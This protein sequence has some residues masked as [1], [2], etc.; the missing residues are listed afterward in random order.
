LHVWTTL[1]KGTLLGL[2]KGTVTLSPNVTM[3]QFRNYYL[4]KYAPAFTKI[5]NV[6]L[7]EVT[8]V[9]GEAIGSNF[10]E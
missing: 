4:N 3:G 5:F 8:A 10:P 6:K 7:V 9:R 1:K 2:H